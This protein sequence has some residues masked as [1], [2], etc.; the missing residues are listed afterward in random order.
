MWQSDFFSEQGEGSAMHQKASKT[1][2][3]REDGGCN[4]HFHARLLN[5][6]A[7]SWIAR[8]VEALIGLVGLFLKNNT[9][10][11]SHSLKADPPP[12]KWQ[13]HLWMKNKPDCTCLLSES[14]IPH[15][16]HP[17]SKLWNDISQIACCLGNTARHHRMGL[18][19]WQPMEI[20]RAYAIRHAAAFVT[21][22]SAGWMTFNIT[23]K[24]L[25]WLAWSFHKLRWHICSDIYKTSRWG[26]WSP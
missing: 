16:L 22:Q 15:A 23:I 24:R 7:D 9:E 12:M 4:L 25:S 1:T 17:S 6:N 20:Q 8:L 26:M 18:E 13:L 19:A 3:T 21:A 11:C 5:I 2:E 10:K 14:K